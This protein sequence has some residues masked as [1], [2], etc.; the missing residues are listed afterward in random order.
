MMKQRRHES[1][2]GGAFGSALGAFVVTLVIVKL[3][4]GWLVPAVFAGA[5]GQGTVSPSLPWPSAA[6]IAALVATVVFFVRHPRRH[7][8][9]SP[10][11]R[12]TTGA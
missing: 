4:W 11:L 1:Q 8:R 5:A 12:R 2:H 3:A 7:A 10:A 6:I 9:R